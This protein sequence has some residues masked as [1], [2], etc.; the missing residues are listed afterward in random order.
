MVAGDPESLIREVARWFLDD[1]DAISLV[2]DAAVVGIGEELRANPAVVREVRESTRLNVRHWVSIMADDPRQQ[3]TPSLTGPVVGIAREVI[4]RDSEHLLASAYHVAKDEAWRLWMQRCFGTTADPGTLSTALEMAF[5]S[6]SSWVEAT[7]IQLGALVRRE[8][9]DLHWQSHTQ[10][11]AM[12]TRVLDEDPS[13]ID[14]AVRGLG[15]ELRRTHLAAVLWTDASTPDQAALLRTANAL[16]SRTDARGMLAVPASASSL[17]LW[18]GST[19]PIDPGVLADSSDDPAVGLA[20]GGTGVGVDGF[21]RSHFEAVS[22]Q[23]LVLRAPGRRFAT[24]DDIALVH[25]ATQ[26]EQAANAY[27]SRVLGR[28]LSADHELRDTV[29]TYVR[30]G[31]SVARTA[32]AVF[33]HRNT[34]LSRL[35]RAEQL[36]PRRY[37]AKSLDVAVA[38]EIDHWLGAR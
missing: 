22:A 25:L 9:E 29:R 5:T 34:V 6:L 16:R 7:L 15:Y 31:H 8:R 1:D 36:L 3:V 37:A 28:L 38:L 19:E 4:R 10:R 14:A 17:W 24:F 32:Q 33:A 2:E 30:E 21:R 35:K 11:L 13:D 20:V 23:R 27:V 26:N 12:T 18:L